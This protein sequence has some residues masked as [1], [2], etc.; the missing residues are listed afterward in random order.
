LV[1]ILGSSQNGQPS[2]D[3]DLTEIIMYWQALSQAIRDE[4]LV[5]IRRA[6]SDT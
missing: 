6:I 3:A 1:G 2:L 4:V 5:P